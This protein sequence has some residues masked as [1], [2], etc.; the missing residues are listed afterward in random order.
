MSISLQIKNIKAEEIE[1][2]LKEVDYLYTPPLSY[3]VN[4]KDYATKIYENA[5][6]INAQENKDVVGMLAFYCNDI[7][8]RV[9]Y[10]TIVGILPEYFGKGIA[11]K[12]MD[13]CI[14]YVQEKD[15]Q[16]IKL[17]VNIKN[18]RA[19]NFYKTFGFK[20][21]EKKGGSLSMYLLF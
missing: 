7:Q 20:I 2:F 1:K 14:R 16:M 8:T 3:K 15:F 6:V 17:E 12:L 18:S 13:L 5:I 19:I 10:I 21:H 4:I 11:R 9:A